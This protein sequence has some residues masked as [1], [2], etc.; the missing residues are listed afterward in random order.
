MG[1]PIKK[2]RLFFFANYE[3]T[4]RAEGQVVN[5]VV[6]SDTAR[7]G[8]VEYPC[9]TASQC[10]G[11]TVVGLSGKSYTVAAGNDRVQ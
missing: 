5:S 1:G 10:P 11:G 2:D 4:R 7:D 6:P 8:I 9:A 3:G